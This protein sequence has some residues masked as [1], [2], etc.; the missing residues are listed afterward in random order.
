MITLTAKSEGTQG[1][2]YVA[3]LV[4]RHKT[5]TFEREFVGRKMGNRHER[6]EA[7]LDTPGLYEVCDI[8]RRGK[9]QRYV[10]ILDVGHR[11]AEFDCEKREAMKV[12]KS[13]DDGMA[14]TQLVR[15]TEDGTGYEVLTLAQAKREQRRADVARSID[16]ASE[17]CWAILQALP[18]REAKRVVAALKKRLNPQEPPATPE[19]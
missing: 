16:T 4:G 8:D 9:S 17:E 15:A 11:L 7:D 1:G 12:A 5:Y 19:A 2:Q 10:F 6:T 18:T 13:L 3:R 14:F